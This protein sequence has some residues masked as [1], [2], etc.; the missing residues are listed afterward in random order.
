MST[1]GLSKKQLKRIEEGWH[2]PICG[3]RYYQ[4]QEAKEC[5]RRCR[6]LFKE[7]VRR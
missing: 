2:C 6:N 4:K 1:E 3:S 7:R 5:N